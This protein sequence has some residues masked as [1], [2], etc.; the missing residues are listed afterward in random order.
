[1][2]G[3][4]SPSTQTKQPPSIDDYVTTAIALAG[5]ASFIVG[6]SVN[7][8]MYY[9]DVRIN[10]AHKHQ[11]IRDWGEEPTHSVGLILGKHPVGM[12]AKDYEKIRYEGLGIDH[13]EWKKAKEQ[14]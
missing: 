5:A 9:K 3:R 6:M 1:M 2:P 14:E 10:P 7:A 13:D 8:F 12:H 11:I 4:Q